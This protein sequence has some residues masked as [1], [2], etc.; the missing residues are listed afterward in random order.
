MFGLQRRLGLA[1]LALVL[2]SAALAADENADGG[3]KVRLPV[4]TVTAA[5][6]TEVVARIPVSGTLVPREEVLVYP[7]INGYAIEKSVRSEE[8]TSEL[9]SP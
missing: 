7:Q 6:R 1:A 5:D 9:Q 8:H 4:V 2:G 3:V